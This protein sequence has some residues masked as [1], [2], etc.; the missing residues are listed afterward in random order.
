[1]YDLTI[2]G[3]GVTGAALAYELSRYSLKVLLVEKENDLA[4]GATRANTAIVHG[5]YDPKPGTLMAKLNARGARR[6][7]E[8]CEKL[9]IEFCKTGSH[10]I[11][12]DDE[13]KETLELLYEQGRIN[14]VEGLEIIDGDEARRRE[15]NL[16]KEVVAALWVP[17]S[18]VINPWEF[19]IAMAEVAVREGLELRR[20]WEVVDI[21]KRKEGFC[22]RSSEGEEVETKFVVNA[23]GVHAESIHSLV[24]KADFSIIPTRGEYFLLDRVGGD[25]VKSIIFQCPKPQGKGVLVSPTVHGNILVGPNAEVVEDPEDCSVSQKAL[26]EVAKSSRRSVPNLDFRLNIRNYAGIRA[27][28]STGDFVVQWAVPKFLDLAAIKSPGLTCA[29]TLAELAVELLAE[30]GLELVEKEAWRGK[31]KIIRFKS[32]SDTERAKLVQN[33]PLYGRVICRCETITE[34]EVV[35]A[36]HREIMPVSIDGLKRRCGTG[37]GRCQGGFCAPKLQKIL[38][39]ET[40]LNMEEIVQ[41]KAGSYILLEDEEEA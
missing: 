38:A 8:L 17:E 1:M 15:P 24:E 25:S 37:M 11:A 12:F 4:M 10:V 14:G 40:G 20:N 2:I 6:C 31:R 13:D 7:M 5:G 23:A 28:S 16:S 41:D 21:E 22:L 33:N 27:N 34:G 36:I 35:A 18:G 29:P 9:D 26:D 19:A 39:R 32:L 30:A 3:G